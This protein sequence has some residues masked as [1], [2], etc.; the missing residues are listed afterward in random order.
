VWKDEHLSFTFPHSCDEVLIEVM[1]ED[2]LVGS[3]TMQKLDFT[4]EST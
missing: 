4:Q 3:I 2:E 1:D